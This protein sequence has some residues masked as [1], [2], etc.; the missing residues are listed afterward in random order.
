VKR[1]EPIRVLVADDHP[2]VR[3][4]LISLLSRFP[5]VKVVG[6]VG[7]GREAVDEY[8]RKRPDIALLDL[9]LP[10]MEGPEVIAA[11]RGRDTEARII[12]LSTF[13]DQEDVYSAICAGAKGYLL[14]DAPV[15]EL[16]RCVRAVHAGETWMAPRAAAN[17]A[18]RVGTPELTPRELQVLTHMVT[19]MSNKEI[20]AK[21]EI[22]EG[23]VKVHVGN[24]FEKLKVAGRTEAITVALKRGIV[25][26]QSNV[27]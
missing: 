25:H 15:E 13:A 14:K 18:A 16:V 10:G 21:L 12:I 22:A 24:I 19:G 27:P 5:D 3:E 9:R 8:F 6:E 4:G 7:T 11:I 23:T 20:G 1:N 2:I 26:I 17:L